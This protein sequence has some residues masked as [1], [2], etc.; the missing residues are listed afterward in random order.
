MMREIDIHAP[1]DD[2]DFVVTGVEDADSFNESIKN[3][4]PNSIYAGKSF[5]VWIVTI[6]GEKFDIALARQEQSTDNTYKGFNI[7]TKD[8][9]IES[10]LQRRDLTINAMAV[11][12]ITMDFIDPYNGYDD[13]LNCRL[14]HVSAAFQEDPLRVIRL[15]RFAARFDFDVDKDTIELCKTLCPSNIDKE[16]IGIELQKLFTVKNENIISFFKVLQ[17]CGWLEKI[18]PFFDFE[19]ELL[20]YS[21]IMNVGKTFLNEI[22]FFS[23]I[24]NEKKRIEFYNSISYADKKKEVTPIK[25]I[26]KFIKLIQT[27]RTEFFLHGNE[28][29]YPKDVLK[30]KF[31]QYKRAGF[32]FNLLP[33]FLFDSILPSFGEWMTMEMRR[34]ITADDLFEVGFEQN[35][36]LGNVLK[37]SLREQDLGKLTWGNK[38][39]YLQDI[40]KVFL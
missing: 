32:D 11:N 22:A 21:L 6:N 36:I 7:E 31:A 17:K 38:E 2:I 12:V 26:N 13:I 27:F 14:F 15:A 30:M 16:R 40:V 23:M 4:F 1:T 3:V 28:C 34:I 9:S 18:F 37:Y 35:I 10:D 39:E 29:Y 5:P 24:E 20:N 19:H 8:I 33:Y 25:K